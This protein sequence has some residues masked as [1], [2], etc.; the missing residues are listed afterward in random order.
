MRWVDGITDS[1]DMSLSKLQEMVKARGAWCGAVHG[2]ADRTEQ[3]RAPFNQLEFSVK[4]VK[5][6]T[7]LRFEGL[8]AWG[9]KQ[10]IRGFRMGRGAGDWV[11]SPVASELISHACV[12]KPS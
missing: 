5:S 11:Q 2:V 12:I 3:Q 6:E 7:P 8:V 10:G 1:M 4:V 9:T